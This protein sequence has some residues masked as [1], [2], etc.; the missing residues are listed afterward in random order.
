MRHELK[1]KFFFNAGFES[2][3]V[4][5]CMAYFAFLCEEIRNIRCFCV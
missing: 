5:A 3:L 1:I 2:L 4:F